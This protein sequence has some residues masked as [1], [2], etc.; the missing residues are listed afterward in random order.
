M[1]TG[2]FAVCSPA[3]CSNDI[4]TPR[5]RP[6]SVTEKGPALSTSSSAVLA[7]A[8]VREYHRLGGSSNTFLFLTVLEA[9]IMRSRCQPRWAFGEGRLPDCQTAGHLLIVS[10]HGVGREREGGRGKEGKREGEREGEK[11]KGREGGMA[12]LCFFL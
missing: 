6:P 11:E 12:F 1:H 7:L 8:A 10:L 3:L 5:R 9:R 4:I 2:K